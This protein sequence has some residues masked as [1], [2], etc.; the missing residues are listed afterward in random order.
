VQWIPPELDTGQARFNTFHHPDR[1][2]KPPDSE[3][4]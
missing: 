1:I 3:E 4:D 2:L